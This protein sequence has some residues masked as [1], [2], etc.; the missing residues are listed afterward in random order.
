MQSNSKLLRKIQLFVF[1]LVP[2][3]NFGVNYFF[4]SPFED[5]MNVLIQPAG[6]AFAIWGPIFLGMLIYSWFQTKDERVESPHLKSAT[7]AGILAGLASIAFV[8]ISYTDIQWLGFINI[9]WHLTAL[10]WLFVS[11]RKQIL[12]EQNKNTHWYYLPTQMYLGWICAATAVSAALTLAET[13]I[14]VNMDTQIIITVIVI[15]ALVVVG[16]IM[17]L[18]KGMTVPLVVIW[19]LCGIIVEN[20]DITMIKYACIAGTIIL[21]VV[22][23]PQIIKRKRLSF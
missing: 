4:P 23:I 2:L 22:T 9:I 11:L 3:V 10:I 20:G 16:I 6:Y 12:L 1:I 19:A 5:D 14:D 17:A 7:Q 21:T 8:P 18:N 15:A 13:G